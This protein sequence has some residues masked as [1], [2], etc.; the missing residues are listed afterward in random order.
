MTQILFEMLHVFCGDFT[1]KWNILSEGGELRSRYPF[2]TSI[3]S[4]MFDVIIFLL[5]L[6]ASCDSHKAAQMTALILVSSTPLLL[7]KTADAF[8]ITTDAPFNA[9][10]ESQMAL[11]LPQ[12]VVQSHIAGYYHDLSYSY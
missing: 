12:E 2:K 8:D 9:F 10:N 1:S 7:I 5:S 11:I 3:H 4:F 6:V